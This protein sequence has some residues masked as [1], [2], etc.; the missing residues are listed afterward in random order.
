MEPLFAPAF[1]FL[2]GND[3]PDDDD[4]QVAATNFE[5]I[6]Q[7]QEIQPYFLSW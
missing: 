5:L 7:G 6:A 1:A 3:F 4:V 2:L